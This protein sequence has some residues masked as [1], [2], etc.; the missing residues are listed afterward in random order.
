MR[1]S[2]FSRGSFRLLLVLTYL[3]FFSAPL[4]SQHIFKGNVT[5]RD[6][7]PLAGANV[8]IKGTNNFVL[9]D[10]LGH[11]KIT[12]NPGNIIEF[13]YVGYGDYRT[14]LGNEKELNISLSEK[15]V[16]LDQ[17]VL[18]GYG[19]SKRKDIT[20]AV[21]KVTAKEFNTGVI[22]N[23]LQQL[24]GKVA[25]VV[26][27]QPGG[28]PNGEFTI[29]VRG[30]TSLEGQ[31][32]LLVIDGIAI[33]D[34]NKSLS[35]LN[36]A[37]VESYDI[38][39]DASAA[40]IYGSRGGNGV[41][42]VTTKK[43]R[44]GKTLVEYNAYL[45]VEKISNQ[46]KV[47][48]ADEWRKATG[49]NTNLDLGANSDWQKLVSQTGISHSHLIGIS[50]GNDQFTFHG[51]VGYIK[52]EGVII[53][54]GKEVITARLTA[55]QKSLKNRLELRYGI[56]S[57]IINRNFLPDQNSTS[58]SRLGGAFVFGQTLRYLPVWPVY[59]PDGSYYQPP[60]NNIN[61]LFLLKELYSKLREN[62][63]QTSVKAD[64]ELLQGLKLGVLGSLSHGTEIYDRFWPTIPGT[65]V[66]SDA[67]K[68]NNNK[69]NISSDIHGNYHNIFGKHSIDITGAYEYN[70][71][72]ND[73]FGVTARGF[74]IPELLNNNL[75]AATNIGTN[76]I[77]SFK[78]EIKLI[79]FLGRVVYNFND[80][81]ILTANFRRDG[82]SKFGPNHR[83][84]NFPSLAFAWLATNE[85]FLNKVKWLNNLKLRVSYGLTGNQE[86]LPPNSY[87]LLYGRSGAY[88][89]NGQFSQSYAVQQ[90][91]NP[92]L[93]WEVRKSLNFG[94]DFSVLGDRIHGTVDV[95]HDKTSDM[96]FLYD[97][98]Q[99]PFL[100][101]KVYANAATASNK[102]I[103][104][105]IGASA[106]RNN[107][108]TWETQ[109][110]V[111][112]LKN[113]ITNLLGKFKGS[114]LSLTNRFYGYAGGGGFGTAPVTLLKEG[115]PSGVFWI[116]QH[117]GIDAGG[118]ELY[119][120]Y[121][122]N[123]KLVGTST[124]YSN[125]DKV[126]I[127]PTPDF[128][129]GFTNNFTFRDFDAS[130]F[131][132]GVQGQKIFANSILDLENSNYLPGRNVNKKALTNGFTDL[133][134]PSTYWLR[135]GSFARLENVTLGY[136]F[137]N[138]RNI[139]KLRIYITATNVFVITKYEGVDPEVR[140]EGFERYIDFNYYPK[141]RGFTFGV[142]MGF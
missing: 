103:E 90:E 94:L 29:R 23:P 53:N 78:N 118:H 93:K 133:P 142:D 122:A 24:Q 84:G 75:S 42:L 67:S 33:D 51:S 134:Q 86:D 5:G 27:V 70:K 66:V 89:Y 30:A 92:D 8:G 110:N 49:G 61:P 32:P 17:V 74:L 95:F 97:I 121:D 129:W 137:K 41:I 54:S 20:G 3:I 109:A 38:L 57:S 101:N 96:L 52:Q 59:N 82:S 87:Q 91:N 26:I 68:S 102:G 62:F 13:T 25:G 45:G 135:D 43:G 124:S 44:A 31:P 19:S 120:N 88:L 81:Y 60:S 47:L 65:N 4:F 123:G 40:A 138:L 72:V 117:A 71:F 100:T 139:S 105:T 10:S 116:P 22:T 18:I 36:P 80:R 37:D 132:R 76:D 55:F 21:A 34:F 6:G 119:N 112:T 99:P 140:T 113:R 1:K 9:T 98:P 58:Q 50:S 114:D 115:Y 108:F 111:S 83:W 130:F 69:Q 104:I 136:R 28:D 16:N 79:S 126:L 2:F 107:H 56:N 128:S 85:N 11:F 48:N 15:L 125:Q 73:G 64:Y 106:I 63:F 131:L 14:I 46:I 12:A 77:Y 127:D 35:T 141:T 7:M 39:K